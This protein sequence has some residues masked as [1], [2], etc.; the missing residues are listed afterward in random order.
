MI[1]ATEAKHT[2]GPWY[3]G[4]QNDGLYVID[5]Q[6]SPAPYDAPIP[7]EG[8]PNVIATPNWRL[9]D[10]EANARLIAQAPALLTEVDFLRRRRG[11]LVLER[12]ATLRSVENL[13]AAIENDGNTSSLHDW[14]ERMKRAVAD[15]R[16]ALATLKATP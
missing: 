16:A 12:D 2:P 7:A 15:A 6:P 8:G 14:N 4:A 3:V 11:Q 5:R 10:H 1:S 9:P 13:I